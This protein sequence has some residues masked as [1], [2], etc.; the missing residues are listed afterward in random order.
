VAVSAADITVPIARIVD[1]GRFRTPPRRDIQG[2]R[3]LAVGLVVVYH[4]RPGAL[5]GGFAGVDVFFVISGFL[6]IGTLTGEIR[7]TGTLKLLDFYARRIRRLLP[8]SSVVLLATVAATLLLVPISR[9][10]SIFGE[11]LASALNVQNWA[12]AWSSADYAH[13]TASASPVQHF[14]SLSVEEQFYLVIPLVLLL[15]ARQAARRMSSA[16][17]FAF[18]AILLVTVVSFV[19]SVVYTPVNHGAAYFVTPTRMW[20]LGL[21]G[22][23][24]IVLH[25]LRPGPRLRLLLGWAGLAAILISAA[26]FSTSLAFPGWIALLPTLGTVGLLVA[27]VPGRRNAGYETVRVLGRQPLRYVGDISYSLY[28]WHWPVIVLLLEVSGS[29]ELGPAQVLFALALSFALAAAS[30]HLVEDPF[31]RRRAAGHRRRGTYLLG[32]TLVAL[33]ALV[34]VAPWQTAQAELDALAG[35]ALL[36]DANPGAMA[37]DPVAPR[38]ARAGAAIRPD[39]AVASA[40]LPLTDRPTCHS[41]DITE[42]PVAGEA[43]TYGSPT[44]A[45]T[46]V[47]VG[48]S[49]AAQFSTVLAEYVGRN[50]G[51]RAKIM[52]RNGCPFN[53]VSPS[54]G[55]NQLSSCTDQNRAELAGILATRPD[56][57][58]TS[59]MSP[60]SYRKDLNWTWESR[61]IMVDGYRTLLD[62][63]SAAKIPVTVIREIPRSAAPVP[64]C[65]ERNRQHHEVCDTPRGVAFPADGDP[66]A[67]AASLTPGVAVADL[68]DWIC[69]PTTCQ[70]VVGNVVVH[71]DNHLTDSYVRT[72]YEPLITRLGLP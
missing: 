60:E 57:V 6:I 20:E 33:P 13:A 68:S 51:W 28:L 11:I 55:G 10:P 12:L 3:A 48:D 34:V 29:D 18:A 49:H 22:L 61:R 70:A 52:V 32:A 44:A 31:R 7:R 47:L 2:L 56:L 17:H 37:L 42:L 58:I 15:C 64:A 30:K 5:P 14:W 72:L 41:Y 38:P 21:G 35:A 69:T 39:P 26:T 43:C 71:R 4:L 66:L 16:P 59:A 53:D 67:E 36:A 24:A 46:M 50:P 8:A 45:K 63:L 54:I 40:D 25:R 65:L 27:G 23:V 19:F 62:P 9:Q 1:T